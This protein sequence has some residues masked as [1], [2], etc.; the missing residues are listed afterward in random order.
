MVTLARFRLGHIGLYGN[1]PLWQRSA[2]RVCRCCDLAV[3]ENIPHFCFCCPCHADVRTRYAD[4]GLN[5]CF[6]GKAFPMQWSGLVSFICE[7]SNFGKRPLSSWVLKLLFG[8]MKVQ[9]VY[10]VTWNGLKIVIHSFIYIHTSAHTLTHTQRYS[11]H[12]LCDFLLFF[13]VSMTTMCAGKM[14]EAIN[15]W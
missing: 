8:I 1:L 3:V 9:W 4:R 6:K 11:E 13:I 15:S 12:L 5:F 14:N 10:D 2:N 7:G